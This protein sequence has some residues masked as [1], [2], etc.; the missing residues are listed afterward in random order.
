[1]DL[2]NTKWA[3]ERSG[4]SQGGVEIPKEILNA[5]DQVAEGN[6]AV[7]GS[8]HHVVP[9]S[10]DFKLAI[11]KIKPVATEDHSVERKGARTEHRYRNAK[12]HQANQDSWVIGALNEERNFRGSREYSN[13]WG[14]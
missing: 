4:F 13:Y 8:F 3:K 11:R 5:R 12:H 1:M 14:P 7:G 9:G 10:H 2:T 6:G